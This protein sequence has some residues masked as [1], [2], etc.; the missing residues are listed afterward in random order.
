MATTNLD[1]R[2]FMLGPCDALDGTLVFAGA[3][4]L[5]E[6]TLL[7]IDTTAGTALK[8]RFVLFDP[9]G[10][11]AELIVKAVLTHDLSVAG[12]GTETVRAVVRGTVN[13]NKLVIDGAADLSTF[14]AA[15]ADGA[16]D[17]GI[18][19][20]DATELGVYDNPQS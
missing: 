9:G 15:H 14:T 10:A 19:I 16:R 6:G 1:A 20:K 8:P 7:G 11:G 5:V 12:A 18:L 3:D 13:Y 2:S 17:A 4:E